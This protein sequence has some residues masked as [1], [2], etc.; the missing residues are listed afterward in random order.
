M[1]TI[2]FQKIHWPKR[3]FLHSL[4]PFFQI[5]YRLLFSLPIE[6]QPIRLP[7]LKHYLYVNPE[8]RRRN[9]ENPIVLPP[10]QEGPSAGV[11]VPNFSYRS[12]SGSSAINC[13][14]SIALT[15]LASNRDLSDSLPSAW[16]QMVISN[17][18]SYLLI[19]KDNF[20]TLFFVLTKRLCLVWLFQQF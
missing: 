16:L 18:W 6:N 20:H 2:S 1:L 9:L 15:S 3:I 19:K 4:N 7:D 11:D 12:P 14:F 5:V 10:S 8:P 17:S 13:L